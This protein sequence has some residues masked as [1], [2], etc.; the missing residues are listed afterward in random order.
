MNQDDVRQRRISP[1]L[2]KQLITMNQETYD[3][4]ADQF[5][6]TR[7]Y[8]WEDVKALVQYIR[9]GESVL[10]LGCGNGRLYQIFEKNQGS[11]T[12]LDQSANLITLAK[13]KFPAGRFEVGEFALL[14]FDDNSFD[15]IWAIASFH[16]IPSEEL[17]IKALHEMKRILKPNGRIIM[18]NWNMYGEWVQNKVQSG[19]YREPAPGDF[20]V[21]W[22]DGSKKNYGDR[23]YHGFVPKEIEELCKHVELNVVEQY[24]IKMQKKSNKE[25]GDNLISIIQTK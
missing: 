9:K 21:P 5:S 6:G 18:L 22:R 25:E 3:N 8:L 13:E 7:D 17:R 1:R 19:A 23:Y 12:G 20:I 14:P 16:H 24:Y 11:Y 15:S 2:A 10:D 4:I